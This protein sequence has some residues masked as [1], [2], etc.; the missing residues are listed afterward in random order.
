MKLIK[1]LTLLAVLNTVVL[2]KAQAEVFATEHPVKTVY[3]H[4]ECSVV[5][6]K[7]NR[8]NL[9]RDH[10]Q[11]ALAAIAEVAMTRAEFKKSWARIVD[12]WESIE[13]NMGAENFQNYLQTV[14]YPLCALKKTAA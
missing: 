3:Q 1:A 9:A 14:Y 13:A 2:V 6:M 8:E 10:Y 4:R 5:A 11:L 12:H 7:M